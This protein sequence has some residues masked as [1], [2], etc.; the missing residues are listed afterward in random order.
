MDQNF[1]LF[2]VDDEITAR[3]LLNSIFGKEYAVE[4]FDSA[5]ACLSRL[6]EVT[7]SLFLLDVGLPGI[8]G[9]AL[10]REIRE[11]PGTSETPVI[12]VSGN[13]DL[14]SRLSGYDS[15]G[16][17]FIV[18]PY[19][20]AYISRRVAL[21]KENIEKQK[22]LQSQAA[23]SE[24]LISLV[25]SNMDEYAILIQ[26]LRQLNTSDDWRSIAEHLLS[27]LHKFRLNGAVQIRLENSEHTLGEHGEDNALEV[28]IMQ[29]VRDMDRIF[30]FRQRAVFNFNT[31]TLMV[32]NMP[33]HDP[34]MCGRLRDHLAIA[35]EC[36]DARVEGLIVRTTRDTSLDVIADEVNK[37]QHTVDQFSTRYNQARYEGA[38]ITREILDE[39]SA[40]FS[41]IGISLEQEAALEKMIQNK[42]NTLIELYDFGEE[43]Q[44]TLLALRER[45]NTLLANRST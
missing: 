45:L 3:L 17:D 38:L 36:A 14:D 16:D 21:M 11:R 43:T 9:Y 25:L 6:N 37:I 26:C 39:M 4:L 24:E 2:I 5:E 32:N 27:L 31:L 18:K 29:H 1:L 41:D 12:F 13:D 23:E 42:T 44:K 7:P 33:L 15:G 30:E 34:E 8:S 10:C 28:S 20:T 35:A 19:S 22:R 40:S